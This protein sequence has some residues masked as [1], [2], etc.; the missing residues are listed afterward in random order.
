MVS[1]PNPVERLA[2]LDALRNHHLIDIVG[3]IITVTPKGREYIQWRGPVAEFLRKRLGPP[4]PLV[5]LANAA[6]AS[7]SP[8]T[9]FTA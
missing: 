8:A 1:V 4:P 6:S 9:E 5:A 2:I 7:P 3:D